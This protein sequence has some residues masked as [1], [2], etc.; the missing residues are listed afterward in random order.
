MAK[1]KI[2]KEGET[3]IDSADIWRFAFHSDYPTFKIKA[4]GESNFTISSGQQEAHADITHSLG[5]SPAYLAYIEYGG[6]VY[7]VQGD[8]FVFYDEMYLSTTAGYDVAV[9]F[10]SYTDS[11]KLRIGAYFVTSTSNANRT[12][13]A[14]YK[15]M[16]DKWQS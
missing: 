3:D 9:R 6:Y 8:T 15:I 2:L 7:P 4:E 16:E 1:D 12:F 13:T 10:Y 5:Y 11:S 14:H